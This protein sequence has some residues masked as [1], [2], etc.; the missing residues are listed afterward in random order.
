MG[1]KLAAVA[2]GLAW[3][4]GLSAP[5]MAQ[6]G[7]EPMRGLRETVMALPSADGSLMQTTIFR[8]PGEGPFPLALVSH[9][10][11]PGNP[12][13]RPRERFAALSREFVARGYAVAVPMRRGFAGSQGEYQEA[14]CDATQNALR[15]ASDIEWALKA[16]ASMS[17]V[18]AD[19][20]ALVG[21][22]YGGLASVAASARGLPGVRG[23]IN[24]AGGLR[25]DDCDW[26]K[27]VESAFER[28]G[29]GALPS[30]WLYGA[31]DSL[32]G[33]EKARAWS[34]AHNRG[35]GRSELVAYG[36]FKDDAH[37]LAASAEGALIWAEPVD[38]FLA[39]LGLPAGRKSEL[40]SPYGE[41]PG[42]PAEAAAS[43]FEGEPR[44]G[45]EAF[46]RQPYPR[47]FASSATGSWS[48]ASEG[49]DPAERALAACQKG[50]SARCEL[51]ALDAVALESPDSA[52]SPKEAR[53]GGFS[54]SAGR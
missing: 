39:R 34:M 19:A 6:S 41:R 43:R 17:W 24:F 29:S 18:Q 5:A 20:V 10:K 7:G 28:F 11:S 2:V 33:P 4:M 22:S 21:Q 49:D 35:G 46:L 1:A 16:L 31:N 15:Q 45:Y 48:W 30:L 26:A 50:S 36:P 9:G 14:R 44:L 53:A 32:F 3:A 8:P 23:V 54:G 47:A 52:S 27:G 51:R 42:E 38:R 12:K 37:A 25:E 13:G 40:A